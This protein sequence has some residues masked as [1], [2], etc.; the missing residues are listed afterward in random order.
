MWIGLYRDD[1]YHSDSPY[2]GT[3]EMQLRL[4]R[5]GGTGSAISGFKGG[6][7]IDMEQSVLDLMQENAAAAEEAANHKPY[8]KGGFD[9]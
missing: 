7:I 9:A 5:H 6:N 1:V 3:I 2:A 8:R 4:N